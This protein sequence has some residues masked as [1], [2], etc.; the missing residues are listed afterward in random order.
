MVVSHATTT[1]DTAYLFHIANTVPT[2]IHE[3]HAYI[4]R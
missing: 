3:V 2:F 4:K 1:G